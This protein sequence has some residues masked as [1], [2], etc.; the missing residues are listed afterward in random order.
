[1]KRINFNVRSDNGLTK[2][3]GYRFLYPDY[4]DYEFAV[5]REGNAINSEKRWIVTELSTGLSI[6]GNN[7]QRGKTRKAAI[8]ETK[9]ILDR[10][11]KIALDNRV[12]E[13]IE[14]YQKSGKAN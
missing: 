3:T 4:R 7:W 8:I 12:A 10:V 1:M 14:Q 13:T 9:E 5:H 6:G 11:G 2:K